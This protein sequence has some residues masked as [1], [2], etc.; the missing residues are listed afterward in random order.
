M[1]ITEAFPPRFMSKEDVTKPRVLTIELVVMEEVESEDGRVEK[2]VCYFSE[3]DSKPLILNK[4][5]AEVLREL[6]GDETE[7]WVGKQIEV[8]F[9][10]SIRFGT[11]KTGGIRV[12]KPSVSPR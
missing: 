6:Y 2:P 7:E 11:R 3:K 4:T 5:N 10:P 9:D 8:Y 1:R 12:R